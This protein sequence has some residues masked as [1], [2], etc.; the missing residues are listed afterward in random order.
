MFPNSGHCTSDD[1]ILDAAGDTT[2][3]IAVD[4]TLVPG[5]HPKYP[6]CVWSHGF[7]RLALVVQITFLQRKSTRADLPSDTSRHDLTVETYD[8]GS[9]VREYSP[10]GV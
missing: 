4:N 10:D 1:H 3:A 2:V 7:S 5:I 8:L 9:G 6:I